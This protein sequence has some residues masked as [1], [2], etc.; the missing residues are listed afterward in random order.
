[1]SEFIFES[2]V[3][4]CYDGEATGVVTEEGASSEDSSP[5]S[6][7]QQA[8]ETAGKKKDDEKPE[9]NAEQQAY[10]N[11]IVSLEK[12][13]MRQTQEA[14]I[15][16][17]QDQIQKA[18]DDKKISEQQAAEQQ[19]K[20]QE[21]QDQWLSK[22]ELLKREQKAKE[23][24]FTNKLQEALESKIAIEKKYERTLV[25]HAIA[26]AVVEHDGVSADQF[27]LMFGRDAKVIEDKPIL[28]FKDIS[29][30]NEAIVSEL[31]PSDALKRMSELPEL[32]G[33]LFNRKGKGGVG[34]NT[35]TEPGKLG[36]EQVD[37]SS[38]THEE[39]KEFRKTP[40]GRKYLGL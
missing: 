39:Y 1:M 24:E 36:K 34:G 3:F 7:P 10:L 23:T 6:G 14:K 8:D 30:N 38:M 31:P 32:Y 29:V 25:N 26:A 17:A 11:K 16:E 21:M 22:E 4:A 40:E 9:F 19:S 37:I 20:L 2:L 27:E 15:R 33:N 5:S 28:V 35:A 12:Q 18:L 13:R